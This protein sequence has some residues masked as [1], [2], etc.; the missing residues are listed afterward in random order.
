M[1]RV[2]GVKGARE[3]TLKMVTDAVKNLKEKGLRGTFFLEESPGKIDA[4]FG[5]ISHEHI[6]FTLKGEPKLFE[7][8]GSLGKDAVFIVGEGDEKYGLYPTIP[9]DAVENGEQLAEFILE[10]GFL[11]PGLNCKSCGEESCK[12]MMEK[13][14]KGER[15][16]EDCPVLSS[17]VSIMCGG[18]K[19]PLNPFTSEIIASTIRGLLSPLKGYEDGVEIRIKIASR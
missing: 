15:K 4:D 13:I 6:S 7:I 8:I 14:M 16:P 1:I 18:K 9:V 10:R 2:L 12:D 17:K 3:K 11:L 5:T 19:L